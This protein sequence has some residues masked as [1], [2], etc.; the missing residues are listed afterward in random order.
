MQFTGKALTFRFQ[1]QDTTG[2]T[3][4]TLK[5]AAGQALIENM[6]LSKSGQ[7]YEFSLTAQ[8]A[9]PGTYKLQ[10]ALTKTGSSSSI[11]KSA[12]IKIVVPVEVKAAKIAG[13]KTTYGT[14]IP[15]QEFSSATNDKFGVKLSVQ[16]TFHHTTMIPNQA[17]LQFQH[18]ES[19]TIVFFPMSISKKDQYQVQKVIHLSKSA[20]VFKYLSGKYQVKIL[21]ADACFEKSIEWDVGSVDLLMAAKPQK[22]EYA[23][24]VK[25]LLHESDTTLKALPEITHIMRSPDTRPAVFVSIFFTGLVGSSLGGFG[26]YLAKSQAN[27]KKFPSGFNAIWSLA[28]L[29]TFAAILVL[30]ASFWVQLTMFTTL[31]YLLGLSCVFCFAGR[32]ALSALGCSSSSTLSVPPVT[33]SVKKD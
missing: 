30:F 12:D 32:R 11:K 16:D 27:L 29:L 3:L 24:Y 22:T 18:V 1:A 23:L 19:G 17:V 9:T 4:K 14:Q 25:P 26:L 10:L 8:Q 13:S 28:F 20:S 2:V 33:K 6:K 31:Y 15:H 7:F 5:D 21:L